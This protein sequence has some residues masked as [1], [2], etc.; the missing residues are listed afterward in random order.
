MPFSVLILSLNLGYF[1]RHP[2]ANIKFN[3]Y[4]IKLDNKTHISFYFAD[5]LTGFDTAENTAFVQEVM[6]DIDQENI[7]IELGLEIPLTTGLKLKGVAAIGQSVYKN[8]PNLYLTSDSFSEA[9]HYGKTNL[10]N[11]FTS[12]GPQRAY[13][14]GFEYNDPKYWWFGATTN[15]FSNAHINVAPITR[16]KNFYT[17]KDGLPFNNYDPNVARELL[18]QEVF[19]PYFLVNIVGGKSWKIDQYYFGFFVNVSN[20]LNKIYKTGG[21]EQS[22]NVNYETLLEDKSRDHPLFG[23]KYWFGYGTSFYTS[24]YFRF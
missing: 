13:S 15:Y 5:G 16:T 7:G 14:F 20:L 23:P 21:Y 18:K 3:T 22:R 11:Y 19:D 8:N 24:V 4:W 9:L 10:K 2:K 1:F 17:D 12:G 6:T